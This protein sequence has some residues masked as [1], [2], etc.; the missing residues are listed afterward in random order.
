MLC[1]AGS[2]VAG[3]HLM[4]VL[5]Y[6]TRLVKHKSN[7]Q[8]PCHLASELGT[9]LDEPSVTENATEDSCTAPLQIHDRPIWYW[10]P[11][12]RHSTEKQVNPSD[13]HLRVVKPLGPCD[14][15][16]CC[17]YSLR[18][19]LY[20]MIIVKLINWNFT[21]NYTTTYNYHAQALQAYT[22]RY[23]LVKILCL[24]P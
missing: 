7:E 4:R 20:M 24:Q 18:E 6:F 8:R 16:S 2:L 1:V 3:A 12:G 5:M 23:K 13:K 15:K 22:N 19:P 10:F 21:T 9:N 11:R 14:N 17:P